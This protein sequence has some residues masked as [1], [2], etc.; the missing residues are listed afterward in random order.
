MRSRAVVKEKVGKVGD[1]AVGATWE[2]DLTG[3]DRYALLR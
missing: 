3:L 2:R 1:C